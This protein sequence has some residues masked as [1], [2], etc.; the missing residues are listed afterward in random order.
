MV[1]VSAPAYFPAQARAIQRIFSESML[2][3][4]EAQLMRQRHVR[5]EDQIERLFAHAHRFADSYDDVNFTPPY[6]AT[7]TAETLIVFGDRDPL[8]PVTM[9]LE[10]REAIPHSYLWV[11]PNGGHSP[12][13]GDAAPAFARTAMQFLR[14]AWQVLPA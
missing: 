3:A 9:A 13:F 5:G 12:V 14:G 8:Y 6:L 10:L 7:I 4:H 2:S 1:I 11:V